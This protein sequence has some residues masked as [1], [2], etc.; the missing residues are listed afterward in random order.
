MSNVLDGILILWKETGSHR[1]RQFWKLL[2]FMVVASIVEVVSIGL[3]VPFLGALSSPSIIY[4]HP[5]AYWIIHFLNISSAE[6][7]LLPLTTLFV[8]AI[9]IS[10]VIRLTLLYF[11]TKFSLAIGADIGYKVY[12][13]TLYQDYSIHT[14]QNSSDLINGII[15]KTNTVVNGVVVPAITFISSAIFTLA[16]LFTIIAINTKVALVTIGGFGGFYWVIAFYTSKKLQLNS[17]SISKL[18]TKLVKSLQEGL[19]GIRDVL[20][21]GNQE[22]YCQMYRDSDL[23]LRK[24][25][26]ENIFIGASP[27]YVMEIVGVSI[28]AIMAYF[29]AQDDGL[30]KT[31]PILGAVALGSQKLLP[32]LQQLY[33]SYA[34]IYGSKK[35]FE[36]VLSIL[37]NNPLEYKISDPPKVIDFQKGIELKNMHFKYAND[38]KWLFND[39][40]L[41]LEKGLCIGF[42]GETGSGKSTFLDIITGLLPPTIGEIKVDDKVINYKNIRS[43]Q[44]HIAHVPQSIYLSDCTI[45][46]N[47][48]FGKHLDDID[49]KLMVESSKK[50]DIH[51]LIEGWND[52]YMTQVGERGVRL[53]GGQRQRIGIA[54]AL[55]KQSNVIVFDEA[56]SALDNSTEMSIMSAISKLD[57]N[58]T[59][60]II[61]HRLTTLKNCEKIIE[62][63]KDAGFSFV[64]Y[65]DVIAQNEILI[66]KNR[67]I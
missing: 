9:F 34:A 45:A 39:V 5:Y 48:A 37:I 14:L 54:R 40:N 1:H 29:M 67:G 23:P 51:E 15:F 38:N 3:V 7:I 58:L 44:S 62:I 66:T 33:G 31:I 20:I 19:G 6:E 35:S 59:I 28:I 36:D 46:E 12:R 26:A 41:F 50:A 10:G 60:F 65:E 16:I 4:E 17:Q 2:V 55:Y 63:K 18:S 64:N 25:T 47:I 32:V 61:A 11:I 52:K 42:I 8:A 30:D 56:T 49:W 13:N 21:D 43:W 22:F 27:R 24:A 57:K 53:S